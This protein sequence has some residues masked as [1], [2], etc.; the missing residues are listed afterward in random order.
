M[1]R[2][3]KSA[4]KKFEDDLMMGLS[5]SSRVS[6]KALKKTNRKKNFV[7]LHIML[8]T[9]RYLLICLHSRARNIL[10]LELS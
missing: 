10:W 2:I 6:K 4:C 5:S 9:T 8:Y 1:S 3:E 7:A